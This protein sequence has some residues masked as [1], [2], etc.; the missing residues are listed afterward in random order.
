MGFQRMVHAGAMRRIKPRGKKPCGSHEESNFSI[1]YLGSLKV[2]REGHAGTH[3]HMRLHRTLATFTTC[4]ADDRRT[5]H[6]GATV[7]AHIPATVAKFNKW[8]RRDARSMN[9]RESDST[10]VL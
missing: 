9:N 4:V 5:C 8:P 7:H 10:I 6:A 2:C 3:G 1:S